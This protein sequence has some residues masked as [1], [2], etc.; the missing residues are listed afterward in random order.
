MIGDCL[1]PPIL[2]EVKWIVSH[3]PG[4]KM[5]NIPIPLPYSIKPLY[6]PQQ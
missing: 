3:I 1:G 5:A 2:L 4:S 6:K